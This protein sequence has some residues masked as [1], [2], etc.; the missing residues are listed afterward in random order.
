MGSSLKGLPKTAVLGSRPSAE[1]RW[2]RH[3]GGIYQL[4]GAA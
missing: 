4:S 3:P 2:A 1:E